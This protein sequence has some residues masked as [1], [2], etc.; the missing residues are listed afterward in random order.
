MSSSNLENHSFRANAPAERILMEIKMQGRQTAA[1]LAKVL[2]ITGEAARQQ[3]VRLAEQGLVHAT[4]EPKGVGRP[5]QLW[6]LTEAAQARFPDT[7]ARL[8]TELLDIIRS[9]LGDCALDSLIAARES[10]TRQRYL[11]EVESADDL[12]ARVATL[13]RLRSEEGY[14]AE[15]REE[16]DGS[17]LLI[18]NHCPICAAATACAGFCR[19]ELAVFRSV[20]GPGAD[21]RRTDH[22][23]AGGRRC[24]YAIRP[25]AACV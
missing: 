14:M 20:L 17:F 1:G 10:E 23:I 25:T 22:I 9:Q 19:A 4:S 15:W 18:E 11:D 6:Q 2:G 5:V 12:A 3:L 24:A 21:I 7:H 13:A 8:T 16:P